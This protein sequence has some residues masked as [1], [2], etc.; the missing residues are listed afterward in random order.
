MNLVMR[1]LIRWII[2][3][4]ISLGIAL[5]A[6]N[7]F[8]IWPKQQALDT[9]K[10][11]TEAVSNILKSLNNGQEQFKHVPK[12][13]GIELQTIGSARL[14][15]QSISNLLPTFNVPSPEPPKTLG[16]VFQIE[17][18]ISRYNKIING[19]DYKAV[20]A[21]S[22]EATASAK[23]FVTYHYEVIKVLVNILEYAPEMDTKSDNA[24]LVLANLSAAN[25]GIEKTITKLRGVPKYGKDSLEALISSLHQVE[26]ALAAYE[27]NVKTTSTTHSTLREAYIVAVSKAQQAI[28]A[29]RNSFWQ[30][31]FPR[32]E[33]QV[34]Q[35]AEKLDPIA[36]RLTNL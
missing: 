25:S 18:Q 10:H 23:K 34:K 2:R 26:S 22:I 14:Y 5:L 6:L 1:V 33:A 36:S 30:T 8:I 13:L 12:I 19:K 17:S 32:V 21:Q 11:Q 20:V 9:I 29:N 35:A 27:A 15:A 24:E 28:L 31:Y 4:V 7:L 16:N 3:I